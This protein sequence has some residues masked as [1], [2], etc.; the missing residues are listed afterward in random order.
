MG[1]GLSPFA[2]EWKRLQRVHGSGDAEMADALLGSEWEDAGGAVLRGEARDPAQAHAYW[3]AL[4]QMLGEVGA[5]LDQGNLDRVTV[6]SLA[7]IDERLAR[8]GITRMR[9]VTRSPAGFDSEA[10]L[11]TVI[12]VVPDDFPAVYIF[13]PDVCEEARA[14][15]ERRGGE[16]T[17]K[18]DEY[19]VAEVRSWLEERG[20][21]DAIVVFHY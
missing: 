11:R 7:G 6:D 19:F 13:P 2:V 20:S 8:I 16:L 5:P 15:F 4:E 17:G 1:Y 21:D 12:P 14:A 18:D 3:Y 9:F 10:L